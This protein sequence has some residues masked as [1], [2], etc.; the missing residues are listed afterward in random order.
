MPFRVLVNA[1][2]RCVDVITAAYFENNPQT[3]IGDG[4]FRALRNKYVNNWLY[5]RCNFN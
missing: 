2:C 3:G 1:T 4:I 5:L